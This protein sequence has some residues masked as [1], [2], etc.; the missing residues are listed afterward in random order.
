M[1]YKIMVGFIHGKLENPRKAWRFRAGKFIELKLAKFCEL[2]NF[3][4][5]DYNSTSSQ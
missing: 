5:F 3:A 2:W 1:I 4:M